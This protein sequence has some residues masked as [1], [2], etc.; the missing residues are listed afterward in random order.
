MDEPWAAKLTLTSVKKYGDDDG[1]KI[2]QKPTFK[3]ANG[4]MTDLGR[5]G[6]NIGVQGGF[7]SG[8]GHTYRTHVA[9]LPIKH[10]SIGTG[11]RSLQHLAD[12]P[13]LSM[14]HLRF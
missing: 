9:D 6:Y 12:T 11:K 2:N 13:N 4:H 3:H 8:L 7:P 14:S 1:K 5:A 10:R